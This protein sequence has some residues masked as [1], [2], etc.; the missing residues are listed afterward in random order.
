MEKI[1]FIFFIFSLFIISCSE[2]EKSNEVEDISAKDTSFED[3]INPTHIHKID[4]VIDSGKSKL[5]EVV[6]LT[7]DTNSQQN[8]EEEEAT[9]L[10]VVESKKVAEYKKTISTK[11]LDL[12]FDNKRD[13]LILYIIVNEKDTITYLS[14]YLQFKNEM[15]NT[16][17]FKFE[18]KIE[19]IKEIK[20]YNDSTITV[21][22]SLSNQKSIK[23]KRFKYI[24]DYNYLPLN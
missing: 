9:K 4:S 14:F 7:K 1:F 3:T 2:N 21:T 12:N 19:K 23:L 16:F 13:L 8:I 6:D 18:E 22:F 17:D 10:E 20:T 24:N 11:N 15:K 5:I